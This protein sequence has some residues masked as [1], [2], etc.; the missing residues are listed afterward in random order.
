[1]SFGSFY[2]FR[3]YVSVAARQQQAKKAALDLTRQG[4][5]LAPVTLTGRTIATTFW[6]Q[7]W[8]RNLESYSDFANRLPRGRSYVRNGAVLDLQ[9]A[10]GEITAL[11]QGSSLY[12]IAFRIS[13]LSAERWQAF[14]MR[15]AG[16]VTNLLDLLQGRL[17]PEIMAEIAAHET[18][19]FPAPGEMKFDCSCPDWADMCKHVAAVLYGIGAR[20]DHDPAL[21][22]TLRGVDM[23]ELVAGASA[24]ATAPLAGQDTT[25][26]LAA[27]T[28]LAE[29]FGVELD[30]TAV[31]A[32]SGRKARSTPTPAAGKPRRPAA[33][34]SPTRHPNKKPKPAARPAASATTSPRK[35]K[36][37][38]KAALRHKPKR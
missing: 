12:R 13:P 19:L 32:P 26:A 9:I 6:G 27:D 4:H 10:P 8:C 11:V 5:R 37:A 38:R 22:F 18:G 20:L 24:A 15:C 29:I 34:K 33:K 2:G 23:Q 25:G 3:P 17:S 14:K 28:D 7:A 16:R 35:K 21:F 30:T 1:M 31:P 36:P